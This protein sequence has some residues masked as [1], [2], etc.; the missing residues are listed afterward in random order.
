MRKAVTGFA[1]LAAFAAG[2]SMPALAENSDKNAEPSKGERELAKMLE[3]Y[4]AGEPVNCLNR[5][6]RDRLRVIND[7]ALV[8]RDGRTIYVNRTTAPQFIDDFDV[9]VF[10]PFGSN[11]CRLDRVEFVDRFGG[12][13]GPSIGLKEFIPYTK[14]AEDN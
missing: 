12:F 2:L 1:A 5:S 11:L 14:I 6:Q 7:T 4:E 3:G 9:P 13:A 10:R 8:F